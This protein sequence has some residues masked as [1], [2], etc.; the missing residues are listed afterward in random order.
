[1]PKILDELQAVSVP[2]VYRIINT[3][4]NT[5]YIG[6][7]TDVRA[8]L[9]NHFWSLND[10]SHDNIHLQ[11]AWNLDGSEV[12]ELEQII[13]CDKIYLIEKE[14]WW[15]DYYL[16]NNT[17]LY[18]LRL[19]AESQLGYKHSEETCAKFKIARQKITQ[20]TKNKMSES[21]LA[22]RKV[23]PETYEGVNKGRILSEEHKKKLCG[24]TPWNKGKKFIQMIGNTNAA[25]TVQSQEHINARV[26]AVKK[27]WADPIKRE[28][29]LEK[30]RL[31]RDEES[32]KRRSNS[33][34]AAWKKKK[35]AHVVIAV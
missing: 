8:R 15:I 21:A 32:I 34:K 30:M 10:S 4:T 26:E 9:R 1:M 5:I 6:S 23:H 35:E 14:Q 22:Y 16:T 12:F 2:G 3:K 18:N 29:R 27:S 33:I 31:A 25:G 7:S 13:Q 17:K 24:R 28:K 11:R 19:R 20:E